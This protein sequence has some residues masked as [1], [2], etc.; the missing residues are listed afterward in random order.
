MHFLDIVRTIY[1]FATDRGAAPSHD[2]TVSRQRTGSRLRRRPGVLDVDPAV[3]KVRL[4]DLLGDSIQ[5]QTQSTYNARPVPG[6]NQLPH[7][8]TIV[9]CEKHGKSLTDM[10][11]RSAVAVE[12]A[13]V[14]LLQRIAPGGDPQAAWRARLEDEVVLEHPQPAQTRK[15]TQRQ[16]LTVSAPRVTCP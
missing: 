8:T 1:L 7:S 10:P 4:R 5:R 13:G 9:I 6:P 12:R 14:D 15:C 16:T 11:V 2:T 3:V